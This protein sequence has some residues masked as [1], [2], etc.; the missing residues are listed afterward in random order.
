MLR[1]LVLLLSLSLI[2]SVCSAWIDFSELPR[3]QT[4]ITDSKASEPFEVE[5]LLEGQGVVWGM[6]FV[7]EDEMLF[8]KRSGTL[9]LFHTKTKKLQVIV[10]VPEVYS[11]GQGGLL[12]IV[13][14]P[15]FS[16]NKRIYFSYSKN[17]G[18]KQTT[19]LATAILNREEKKL[20]QVKDIFLARPFVNSQN[21]FGSRLAFN[22]EGFLFMTV[23]DRLNRHFAQKLNS[24]F[25]KVLRLTDQGKAPAN[26]P[27]AKEKD[28]FPEIWS[29]GHR[30]PQGLFIDSNTNEVWEQE[31]G[32]RGGDEINL[33]K[34]GANYGWPI[35][36]Y[37]REYFGPK[38]GKGTKKKGLEQPIKY[39]TPS[40]APSGLLIYSGKKFKK[41]KGDFFSG[42]LALRHLNRLKIA[43]QK[44]LEEERLLSSLGVRVRNV[45]EG[46]RGFIY[47]SVDDGRIFRLKPLTEK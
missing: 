11:S 19:V 9:K 1:Y 21:H 43:K 8:T 47:V 7:N 10:G 26:N 2:H 14:H 24:H 27:F 37:G 22:K 4:L 13:L 33:I 20:E 29:L 30:N 42:A 35:I 39:F 12:D 23:G 34:K 3:S 6:I 40:I 45:M 32:P 18:S 28:A 25:G 31:H 16:S 15:N 38:I 36:T 41:W 44:V 5:V 46:P 17:K